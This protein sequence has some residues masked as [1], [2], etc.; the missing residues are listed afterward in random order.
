MRGRTSLMDIILVAVIGYFVLRSI[1]LFKDNPSN[2]GRESK[3]MG[4]LERM[5]EKLGK[6]KNK[7]YL[8]QMKT[9]IKIT[10]PTY[11]VIIDQQFKDKTQFKLFLDVINLSLRGDRDFSVYDGVQDLFHI[12]NQILKQSII[13]TY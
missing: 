11:G 9:G 7:P 2:T 8:C 12:P 13:F 6:Q 3:I 10:H 5:S 4:M 1:K